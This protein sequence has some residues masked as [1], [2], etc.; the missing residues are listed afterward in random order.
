MVRGGGIEARVV[1]R[2]VR[3]QQQRFTK[4]TVMA[5]V[6]KGQRS[7]QTRQIA[8]RDCKLPDAWL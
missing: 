8:K 3:R 6:E 5:K 2:T 4:W 7:D 1:A